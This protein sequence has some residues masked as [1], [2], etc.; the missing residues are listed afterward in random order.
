[1]DLALAGGFIG[2]AI[3]IGAFLLL[4]ADVMGG[5]TRA[6]DQTV[7]LAFRTPGHPEIPLGPLWV[8]EMARDLTSLGSVSILSVVFIGVVGHLL[9]ARRGRG[10]PLIA[11]SVLGGSWISQFLKSSYD[12]PRP[13][14]AAAAHVFT[15]SFPSGHA[16]LSSV[17][18]LT[19]GA[20]LSRT[21]RSKPLKLFYFGFPIVLTLLIGLTRLYLG[22]HYPTDV[23]AGWCLGSAWAGLCLL[24]ATLI[25]RRSTSFS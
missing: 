10:A 18:Y 22:V 8:E 12:R 11:I 25:Q 2:V 13:E 9:L 19:L 15:A 4:A 23:L 6:F 16:M 24:V 14:I 7:L 5:G 1:M 20:L 3:L 21:T 17:T